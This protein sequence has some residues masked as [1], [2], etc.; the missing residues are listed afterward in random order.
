MPFGTRIYAFSAALFLLS[1][2]DAGGAAAS[3]SAIQDSLQ[4]GLRV[5]GSI[6]TVEGLPINI[7][8]AGVP[9]GLFPLRLLTLTQ[10]NNA[11][12]LTGPDSAGPALAPTI[13]L[14]GKSDYTQSG[15][16]TI[17]WK[18]ENDST[19]TPG[20]IFAT[21]TLTVHDLV[22]PTGVAAFY[23]PAPGNVPISN[24]T[25][26]LTFVVWNG[27]AVEAD[28]V[29]WNGFRVRRTIDG[30]SPIPQEVA[31]QYVDSLA[32]EVGWFHMPTS[33]LCF[34]Q[35]APCNPDSFLFTGTGIFFK[36]FQNNALGNGRFVID[37]PPGAPVDQC[38]SCWVFAD[39]ATL[40]GF[41]TRYAVST[42]GP[43]INGGGDYVESPASES[44]VV[45]LTP[46]TAPASNLERVAVVPNPFR[47][48]AQWD[49]AVGEERIHFIHIPGG[50][51][52]RIF[53]SNAE[54]IRELKMDPNSS[55]GGQ[56]GE[57]FWDLRNGEG[58]KV[59]SGIYLYQVQTPEGRTRKGHFVIIK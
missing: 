49:P 50:S 6:Q 57:L 28:P 38:S 37:Y 56:T 34:A 39:L 55:P 5:P 52:I 40:A 16:Y 21:T 25:G 23:V 22:P 59:V 53:T 33:P 13:A 36:G 29:A 18:A 32:L 4:D 26:V 8:G 47:A 44:A 41:R 12:F 45:E 35:S 11:P 48:S 31:G 7:S 58:R 2:L 1:A 3:T 46:A 24:G 20:V 17:N 42:L 27:T 43:F 19:P 51:T 30:V 10:T 54:L 9:S 15:V 14:S